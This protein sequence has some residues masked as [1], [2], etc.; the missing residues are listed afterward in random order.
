MACLHYLWQHYVIWWR[1]CSAT[2]ILQI[3]VQFQLLFE[4][5]GLSHFQAFIGNLGVL[6]SWSETPSCLSSA[7]SHTDA[8]TMFT[9]RNTTILE[10]HLDLGV[11]RNMISSKFCCSGCLWNVGYTLFCFM[12][13][14]EKIK[15]LWH[16]TQQHR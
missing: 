3:S 16:Y 4:L 14:F 1:S 13:R 9:C 12:G 5:I 7:S 6:F 8:E 15:K 2:M 10:N 11:C